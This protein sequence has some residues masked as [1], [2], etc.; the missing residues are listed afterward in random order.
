[1]CRFCTSHLYRVKKELLYRLQS[2][3]E[4]EAPKQQTTTTQ[5]NPPKR[6]S[7]LLC[8]SRGLVDVVKRGET[9]A[10]NSAM[11]SV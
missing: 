10:T 6:G 7:N 3:H 11:R 9:G 5:Q 1:M 4:K 8:A 2:K